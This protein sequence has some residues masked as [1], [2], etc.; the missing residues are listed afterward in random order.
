[1]V[2]SGYAVVLS[3]VTI[4]GYASGP[5]TSASPT[6]SFFFATSPD[7]NAPLDKVFANMVFTQSSV[8][9]TFASTASTDP[10]FDAVVQS[11]TDGIDQYF[12]FGLSD[13]AS[14]EGFHQSDW[15][16]SL[17]VDGGNKIDLYGYDIDALKLTLELLATSV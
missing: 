4:T 6:F 1:M 5:T 8:G 9:Q 13:N 2:K 14:S 3:A 12:W 11:L 7:S 17:L 10:G 16:S 15:F